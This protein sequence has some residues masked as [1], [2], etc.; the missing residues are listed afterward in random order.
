MS[1]AVDVPAL[2]GIADEMDQIADA[3]EGWGEV[4]IALSLR[5]RAARVREA[6]GAGWSA[7]QRERTCRMERLERHDGMQPARRCL[8]CGWETCDDGPRYC[9]GCGARVVDDEEERNG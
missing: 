6:C 2:L 7:D 1:G 5:D 8:S 3:R 4:A 9:P